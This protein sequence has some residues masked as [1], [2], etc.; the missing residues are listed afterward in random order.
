MTTELHLTDE[1]E[2]VNMSAKVF[3]RDKNYETFFTLSIKQSISGWGENNVI[4]FVNWKDREDFA[5]RIY[6]AIMSMPKPTTEDNPYAG[7]MTKG[8]PMLALR[9]NDE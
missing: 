8:D 3:E 6:D 4:F 2:K 9:R 1:Y 7:D 5:E